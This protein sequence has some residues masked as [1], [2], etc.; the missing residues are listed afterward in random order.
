MDRA[1]ATPA[2]DPPTHDPVEDQPLG[3][4]PD[5][6]SEPGP[7]QV[8][9]AG[10]TQGA[11]AAPAPELLAPTLTLAASAATVRPGERVR[12]TGL[13]KDG[14]T[15]LAGATVTI[16]RRS[17]EQWRSITTAVAGD[18][19]AYTAFTWVDTRATVRAIVR[20]AGRVLIGGETTI[21][22]GAVKRSMAQRAAELRSVY[23]RGGTTR[24]LTARERSRAGASDT[25][26]VSYQHLGAS[27]MLVEVAGRSTA[28]TWL[29][30]GAIQKRYIA[31]GGPTGA[32]GVPL[33]DP[34]CGLP[35]G[36][37]LQT[38]AH[39]TLY[40]RPGETS[41]TRLTGARGDIVAVLLTQVGYTQRG[42]HSGTRIPTKFQEWAGSGAA[43]CSIFLAWGANR[44][45]HDDII[46]AHRHF[47]DYRATLR[48]DIRRLRTPKAGALVIMDGGE[49]LGHAAI[50]ESVD[51]AARRI[52]IIHGNWVMKV[53]RTTVP[54]A[55]NMEFYWPY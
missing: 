33:Q 39:G 12:L 53:R 30:K 50:V 4:A 16:Q 52:T 27:V 48:S 41:A 10:P 35:D 45:G 25:A 20:Q 5:P 37:C 34:R 2:P 44:A 15:V 55:T 17:D 32:F 18:G 22:V 21:A 29:V 19:G 13:A 3:A 26:R 46:P 51:R 31:T 38:F 9:G 14:N 23:G 36:G 11:G 43:W 54:V 1:D 8:A 47:R 49:V 7:E 42:S 40:S 6:V 24:T 28:K